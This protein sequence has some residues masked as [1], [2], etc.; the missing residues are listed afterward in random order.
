MSIGEGY[1]EARGRSSG[2][3]AGTCRRRR[4]AGDVTNGIRSA[5]SEPS[6]LKGEMRGTFSGTAPFQAKTM[7]ESAARALKASK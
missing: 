6:H 1:G 2:A 5:E 7:L 4:Y 3:R